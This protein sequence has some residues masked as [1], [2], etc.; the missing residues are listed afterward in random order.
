MV[1]LQELLDG[2]V[3]GVREDLRDEAVGELGG[4]AGDLRRHR[5]S[6]ATAP[7]AAAAPTAR[8]RPASL[9]LWVRRSRG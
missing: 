4:G 7:A 9:L 1:R 3:G 2:E 6:P 8:T 5:R